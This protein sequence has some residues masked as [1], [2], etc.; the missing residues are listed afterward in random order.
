MAEYTNARNLLLQFI[1]K[2]MDFETGYKTN[3]KL[4]I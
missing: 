1:S 4:T 3:P 2:N